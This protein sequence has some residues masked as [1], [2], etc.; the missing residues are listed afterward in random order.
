MP[1]KLN[2]LCA[3]PQMLLDRNKRV[4][5]VNQK[6]RNTA[7]KEVKGLPRKKRRCILE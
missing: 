4:S 5:Q 2:L 6:N 7:E 1:Q 3:P